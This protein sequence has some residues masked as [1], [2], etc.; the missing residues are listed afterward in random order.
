MLHQIVKIDGELSG[1][2]PVF[3]CWFCGKWSLDGIILVIVEKVDM[4]VFY[5]IMPAC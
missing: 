3:F 5:D 4:S 2:I 1:L